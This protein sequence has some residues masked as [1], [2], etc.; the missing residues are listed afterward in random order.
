MEFPLLGGR[1]SSSSIEEFPDIFIMAFLFI[2]T[3][4]SRLIAILLNFIEIV[5]EYSVHVV[6]YGV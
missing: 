4:L 5:Y 1:Q 3:L 6:Q 2:C